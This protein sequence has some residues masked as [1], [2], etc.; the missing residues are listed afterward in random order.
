MTAAFDVLLTNVRLATLRDP[1]VADVVIDAA[2][3][4]RDGSIAWIGAAR[5]LPRDAGAK[6]T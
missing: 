5:D 4:I 2:L 6:R 1:D 3:G